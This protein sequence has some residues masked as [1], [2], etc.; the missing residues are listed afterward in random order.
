MIHKAQMGERVIRQLF[1]PF[2]SDG[3]PV[4][5]NTRLVGT[6][7]TARQIQFGLKLLF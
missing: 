6:V 7:T 2:N 3:Q 1:T 5:A 4:L